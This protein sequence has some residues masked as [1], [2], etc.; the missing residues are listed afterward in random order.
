[1]SKPMLKSLLL[2]WTWHYLTPEGRKLIR[3]AIAKKGAPLRAPALHE[4]Q[5]QPPLPAFS[6]YRDL[7]IGYT[8][9]GAVN[10]QPLLPAFS[11]Y[12]DGGWVF[13][14]SLTR[15]PSHSTDVLNGRAP[16]TLPV[17]K[18]RRVVRAEAKPESIGVLYVAWPAALARNATPLKYSSR[19]NAMIELWFPWRKRS[20]R[21]CEPPVHL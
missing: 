11:V 9:N 21:F 12:R 19:L 2:D 17:A 3:E 14:G 10:M 7:A 5:Q 8:S 20:S 13:G 1:M 18:A 16:D 15:T 4:S 6:V